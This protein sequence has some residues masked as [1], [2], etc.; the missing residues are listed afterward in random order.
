[1]INL[2][3]I[4]QLVDKVGLGMRQGLAQVSFPQVLDEVCDIECHVLLADITAHAQLVE[5]WLFP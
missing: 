2:D 4:R 1:M 3:D 5:P